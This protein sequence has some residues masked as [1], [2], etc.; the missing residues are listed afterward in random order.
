MTMTTTLLRRLA[1][2]NCDLISKSCRTGSH[3]AGANNF[4]GAVKVTN[5][6]N[7]AANSINNDGVFSTRGSYLSLTWCQRRSIMLNARN[8]SRKTDDVFRRMVANENR[9]I[10]ISKLINPRDANPLGFM[11]GGN[12]LSLLEEAGVVAAT[13][14]INTHRDPNH[15][16]CVASLA[17][18]E[19]V[20]FLHPIHVGDV[21][22]VDSEVTFTSKHSCEVCVTIEAMSTMKG[23][24]TRRLTTT[25]YLWFVPVYNS[26]E[27]DDHS[28]AKMPP[29]N[30]SSPE[31]EAA[32]RLRYETQV[33]ERSIYQP[34]HQ[35]LPMFMATTR[36]MFP[37]G[38][39]RN[40]QLLMS[41]F[42]NVSDCDM[43]GM[44]RGGALMKLADEACGSSAW[45]HSESLCLTASVDSC[46]FRHPIRAGA[47]VFFDSYVTFTSQKTMEIEVVVHRGCIDPETLDLK[48][49]FNCFN[50][51]YTFIPIDERGKPRNVRQ[52]VVETDRE[53]ETFENGQRRH[54]LR[55]QQRQTEKQ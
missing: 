27:L 7:C 48:T 24:M 45:L 15:P 16:P 51:L 53:K 43:F 31:M 22:E 1:L 33:K 12:V 21:V 35:E 20:A 9:T 54:E 34:A 4:N 17:R 19:K 37:K 30:Y 50:A 29:M 36:G 26:P 25:A 14:H 39:V 23:D 46:N 38:T 11:H 3:F 32:G 5:F 8:R 13:R 10:E 42:V 47:A 18:M 49:T 52:L 2:S 40:S 41:H 44:M 55:K 28:I 6:L